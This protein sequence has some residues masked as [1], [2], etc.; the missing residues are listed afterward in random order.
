MTG[1]TGAAPV[2][3]GAGTVVGTGDVDV[4]A[5][6]RPATEAL[7][8]RISAG[9]ADHPLDPVTVIVPSNQAGLSVRRLLGGGALGARGLA[10][11]A[12]VTPFRLAERLG[13]GELGERR[14]L[15]NPVLGAAARATLATEP[16]S[17][18]VVADHPATV[19]AL[20]A[21][22]AE[23]SRVPPATRAR[24]AATGRRGAEAVRLVEAVAA[25]LRGHHDEDDLAIAARARLGRDP[26]AVT[27]LG[28]VVWYLPDRLS[29]AM[30]DL[31][32][33]VLTTADSAV[34]V[35]MTGD[36]D[37][38]AGVE[39]LCGRVGVPV[40][41][42]TTV[43]RAYAER[44]ISVSDPEEEVRTA[45]REVVALAH[46]GVD[47]DRIAVFFPSPE[48]YARTLV[49]H[50]DTA[51]LP[52]NGPATSRLADCVAGRALLA[53]L[54]LPAS[55]WGRVQVIALLA[56]APVRHD[57]RRAPSGRWDELSR[58]AG[59]VT[60][61]DGW[62]DRLAG[63]EAGRREE[64]RL[65]TADGRARAAGDVIVS[66]GASAAVV[67]E[68]RLTSLTEEA[69]AAAALARFVAELA[70]AV[71]AVDT[72]TS[73]TARSSAA[74]H[75]LAELLGGERL[76]AGWPDHE[77][78][79]AEQVD[80]ALARL[81]VLDEIDSEPT[82]ADFE[83]AV[84]AE[85]DTTTGRVGR[86]G[87]GVLVVPL[88]A[89]VGLDLDA[90]IVVGMVE[91]TCPSLPREDFLL[92][93]VARAVAGPGE[94][95]ERHRSL[96]DQ[97]RAL[98]VALASAS[99]RRT[100]LLPRGDLR[101]RRNRLPSRWVLDELAHRLG[102]PVFTSDVVDLP[103]AVIEQ[104][105][106]HVAGIR[107]ADVHASAT[108]ADLA[109]LLDH[110]GAG[111]DPA[112]HPAA[113]GHLGRG[114]SSAHARRGPS[115]TEWDGNLSDHDLPSPTDGAVASAT[116]LQTWAGCGMR[117]LLGHVL[118]VGDRDDPEDVVEMAASDR[119][120]AVHAALER[121]FAEVLD[122][123]GG[124]PEPDQA[125]TPGDRAR[126]AELAD[127]VLAE[128]EQA[129]R[130]GRPLLWRLTRT[131]VL[132]DLDA[133]L[134]HDDA[135]RAGNRCRPVAVELAFGTDGAP[136]LRLALPDGRTLSL[137]GSIDRVDTTDAGGVI[138]TD[139]KTGRDT[140]KGLTKD[141]V[142]GGT[143]LQLGVYA[144]AATATFGTDA[145]EAQYWM[146]SRKAGFVRRG[147]RWTGDR[148]ARFLDVVAAI[149]EGIDSGTF[150]A[151]PGP[152]DSFR[153]THENCTYCPFDVVCPRDRDDHERAKADA[154]ELG[155]LARL[156]L[157]DAADDGTGDVAAGVDA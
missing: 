111:G 25:R 152:Y 131:D 105:A 114:L 18:R 90:V 75:L 115:F 62:H 99:A 81:V 3:G 49:E 127:E 17:L 44:I 12:F 79:A 23:L 76:R 123:P 107:G 37:A 36:A 95:A 144:E 31:V 82:T 15:T 70:T 121:F 77:V 69:D 52:H 151:R 68:R 4:V 26:R 110:A 113:G 104:V 47:L 146:V 5:Y 16:G 124:P 88:S 57:D 34:V 27:S 108:E 11:V 84:A 125:W 112:D 61:L 8:A 54:T 9:Q 80:A 120:S 147:Y 33:T 89:A 141:P 122:R 136:P 129:G 85:L 102:R 63:Y 10:N 42:E 2:D 24:I 58:R 130:S 32:R 29:P 135:F 98:L 78:D 55:G 67:S 134:G 145:V 20:V 101:D 94:L 138:V 143:T 66:G 6:G 14:P 28:V 153:G 51:G 155:V 59:V 126:L 73:W 71:G 157:P 22:Y 100:L 45:V 7:A 21:L 119:G 148:R 142:A 154:P 87:Q 103:V 56:S 86:F 60:G 91:G 41:G 13:A 149:V 96:E 40:G 1:G 19:A 92:P 109:A 48:P 46:T 116:G 150:P 30:A 93:D 106:S 53:A 50:L 132:A 137:R 35:G 118:G 128:H 97:H 65:A 83:Q 133:F 117:Y 74:R 39:E 139:Y 140:Y 64:V 72:A 156:A 38:D 43:E